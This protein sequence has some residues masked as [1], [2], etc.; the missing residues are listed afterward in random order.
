M[1]VCV[2]QLHFRETE[3]RDL[4]R[5]HEETLQELNLARS[6]ANTH[7]SSSILDEQEA[8]ELS[9]D[10]GILGDLDVGDLEVNDQADM[11]MMARFL[12]SQ[13]FVRQ[14]SL[15]DELAESLAGMEASRGAAGE[16][17]RTGG[18]TGGRQW[19]S[20]DTGKKQSPDRQMSLAD[21]LAQS[22]AGMEAPRGGDG[23]GVR[24]NGGLDA[25]RQVVGS[26]SWK[27]PS[28]DRPMSLADEFSELGAW[29]SPRMQNGH[30]NS[31]ETWYRGS[32]EHESSDL[33]GAWLNQEQGG[34]SLAEEMQF[35]LEN[36]TVI[37]NVKAVNTSQCNTLS[38]ADELSQASAAMPY[39]KVDSSHTLVNMTQEEDGGLTMS[40]NNLR[41]IVGDDDDEEEDEETMMLDITMAAQP[42]MGGVSLADELANT[43]YQQAYHDDADDEEEEVDDVRGGQE[44]GRMQEVEEDDI[45]VLNQETPKAS[46]RR[47]Q[48]VADCQGKY[49]Q[50]RHSYADNI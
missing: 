40:R 7:C 8:G 12:N 36:E 37:D 43:G 44:R 16:G 14:T 35:Q 33:Q 24:T 3:L 10:R 5:L 38:L 9:R 42:P 11:V 22:L 13:T 46:P 21:E 23:E 47:L 41:F 4:S 31:E 34:R 45:E 30:K 29:P 39:S 32:P 28:Q 6:C 48:Q 25:R 20:S 15:A 19:V 50:V 49:Q 2:V 17:L 26:D 18:E 27:K 1:F